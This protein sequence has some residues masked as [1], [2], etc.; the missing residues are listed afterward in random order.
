MTK[1]NAIWTVG[2]RKTSVARARLKSGSGKIIVNHKDINEYIVGGPGKV[3]QALKPLDLIDGR[4]KFDININV[5]GGG[6]TGQ[7][8]AIAHAL[9]RALCEFDGSLRASLKKEGFLTRDN[10]M[11]ERKKYGLHKARR[12]TQ[13]SKR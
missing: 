11:V 9:S 7:I 3:S 6:I 2:R 8:G 13:F 12:G 4:S 10:R 1:D 5:S